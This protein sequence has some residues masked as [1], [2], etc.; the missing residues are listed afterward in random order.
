[1]FQKSRKSSYKSAVINYYEREGILLKS[2]PDVR[3]T[4]KLA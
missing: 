1:L 2:Q 4:L 3:I